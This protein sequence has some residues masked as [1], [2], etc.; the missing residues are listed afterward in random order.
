MDQF[1]DQFSSLETTW[2]R[3]TILEALRKTSSVNTKLIYVNFVYEHPTIHSL[4][5]YISE[6]AQS[7]PATALSSEAVAE[8][9][10]KEMYAMV[11][12]YS[13]SFPTQVSIAGYANPEKAVVLLTGSTGGLGCPLLAKLV[14]SEDVERVYALNR[15]SA[16]GILARQTAAFEELALDVSVLSSPKLRL[17]EADLTIKTLGLPQS[18]F[19]EVSVG[20]ACLFFR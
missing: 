5:S 15:K 17:L 14:Q 3:S 6:L 10:V 19:E 13:S 16:K 12:K 1:T 2:V 8:G 20:L 4:A 11:E 9:K 7:D 18:V